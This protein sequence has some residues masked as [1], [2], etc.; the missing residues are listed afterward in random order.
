MSEG[1]TERL[2][3]ELG[4]IEK[5]LRRH[6]EEQAA[7]ASRKAKKWEK[8]RHWEMLRW[9]TSY[10][11]EN[12]TEWEERD[13]MRR[14]RDEEEKL[15]AED[16]PR[17]ETLEDKVCTKTDEEKREWRIQQA[18]K[19]KER[20]RKW[21]ATEEIEEEVEVKVVDAKEVD[22]LTKKDLE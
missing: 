19:M 13:K 2:E 20:W 3:K 14:E 7:R 11:E 15:K 5:E 12:K 16:S 1:E 8:E 6:E 17:E 9:I 21:R 4:R 10:I 18:K 22:K